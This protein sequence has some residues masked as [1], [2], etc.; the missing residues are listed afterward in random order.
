MFFNF[1]LGKEMEVEHA[2]DTTNSHQEFSPDLLR[3]YY[4]RIFPYK[5]MFDWLSYGNDP[6]KENPS[7]DKE[8][9]SKREWSFTID[10]D[11][12][13]RY[14]SFRDC[15]EMISAI[16][17]RQPHKIDIGA[18][19]T[20]CPKDHTTI[21]PELFKPI[22]RELVFDIDMTD[23]DNIRT[24]CKEANICRKC[25][26]YMTSAL[27]VVDATL[28]EDFG[29]KHILWIYSGRRGIHCWVSDP[30]ARS[31]PNDARGAIV[32]YMTVSVGTHENSDK[33]LKSAFVVPFH[34]MIKRAYKIMEPYFVRHIV[35]EDC[36]GL[37]TRK[38]LYIPVL[39][40]LPND[41]I[42]MDLHREW[43][44][45]DPT[46]AERWEQIKKLTSMPTPN[47]NNAQ[48]KRKINYTELEQWRY[49]LVFT[50][51]Y[52]RLDVNVS[53]AQNHL[54]KSPFCIHPKTGRV[55]IPIDPSNAD[56]FDPF[57]VPTV[58]TLMD[59]VDRYDEL[60]PGS[61]ATPDI[62][63]TSMKKAMRIFNTS[64][65]TDLNTSIRRD[66]RDKADAMSAMSGDF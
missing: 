52:P 41:E 58:R 59:E 50:H 66:F 13:I 17:K 3:L 33:H 4:D 46:G 8:Y 61:E 55:C 40:S 35:D 42:R 11:I 25:W 47:A 9:F 32:E 51:C 23:Y 15:N 19:Y 45:K 10:G 54:L 26:P 34:P 31:L 14:Q 36:Q 64:F 65:M 43:E 53:K 39:N 22:E 38:E 5:E 16:Q 48:K 24:C 37:L 21:K 7:I 20:A 6:S 49:E 57:E 2:V 44:S 27:K 56:Q 29:F 60:N 1:K 28:R 62:Q 12:Y 63:K 18:V 30:I